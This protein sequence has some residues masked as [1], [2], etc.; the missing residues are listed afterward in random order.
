MPAARRAIVRRARFEEALASRR[1]RW[2]TH[3]TEMLP[4]AQ[5]DQPERAGPNGDDQPVD[6]SIHPDSLG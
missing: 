6:G 2:A 3:R 5:D 4:I 1:D